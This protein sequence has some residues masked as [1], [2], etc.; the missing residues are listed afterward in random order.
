MS[1]EALTVRQSQPIQL[2]YTAQR[3]RTQLPVVVADAFFALTSFSLAT[4]V[5]PNGED[6][7]YAFPIFMLCLTIAGLTTGMFRIVAVHPIHELRQTGTAV[8]ASLAIMITASMTLTADLSLA[9]LILA[10][11]VFGISL[12]VLRALVRS[13]LARTSW[14]GVR[15]FVL[16]A[17]RRVN[18]L[19]EQHTTNRTTGLIPFGFVEPTLPKTCNTQFRSCYIGDIKAARQAR[20]QLSVHAAILHRYGR[21]G[22]ELRTFMEQNLMDFSNVHIAADDERLPMM[23]HD[24]YE[25]RI[26]NPLAQFIKRSI[27]LAV[28]VSVVVLGFPILALLAAWTYTQ[29]LARSSSAMNASAKTGVASGS[30]S[31]ARWL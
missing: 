31:S 29:T 24:C 20:Q 27:D 7:W 11:L 25:N 19:M 2:S 12:P 26:L 30:G 1:T 17:G 16:G 4:L 18:R 21:S 22:E 5:L 3:L 6:A 23:W 8:L 13:E 10:H 15:C 9:V 14:W 28:S